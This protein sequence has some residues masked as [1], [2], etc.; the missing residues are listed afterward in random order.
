ML[1]GAIRSSGAPISG[2]GSS[3]APSSGT[4][5]SGT[6]SSG[7]RCSGTRSSGAC[8]SGTLSSGACSSGTRSSGSRSRGSCRRWCNIKSIILHEKHCSGKNISR[9][10]H[11]GRGAIDCIR[12]DYSSSRTIPS[13]NTTTCLISF[14][15][16]E[17]FENMISL[18]PDLFVQAHYKDTRSLI[19]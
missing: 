16:F 8:S 2:T 13:C 19:L 11:V 6:R 17:I 9:E 5:S 14:R 15:R 3:G 7:S 1:S 12:T 10:V 4:G 18:A